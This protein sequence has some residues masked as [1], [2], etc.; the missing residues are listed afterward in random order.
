VSTIRL[1]LPP[2]K[3]N[4]HGATRAL[5]SYTIERRKRTTIITIRINGLTIT[6]EV[7]P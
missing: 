2:V 5:P 7:P 4:V 1:E 6:V 3:R